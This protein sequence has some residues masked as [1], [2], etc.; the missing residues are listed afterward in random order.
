[1]IRAG[2]AVIL[3]ILVVLVVGVRFKKEKT[4]AA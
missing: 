4:P 1:M 3:A 2:P